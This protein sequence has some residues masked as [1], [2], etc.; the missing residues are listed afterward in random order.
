MPLGLNNLSPFKGAKKTR[1]RVGRGNASGSGNYS[2]KGMKGQRSRAGVGGL[3]RLGFKAIL[4]STPKLR[5][6][7]S[8]R[9]AVQE[10]NLRMIAKAFNDGDVVEPS[11]LLEAGLIKTLRR[12]VKV[13]ANGVIDKKVTVRK[14]GV[15]A[16][17]QA[18]I[19]AAGGKVE[20]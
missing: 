8:P 16:G 18:K 19:E 1:D 20:A 10:V 4:Q 15:S 6:F 3:K 12:K 9:A 11:T 5:G 2:G 14:C 7:K 17:A 13:L